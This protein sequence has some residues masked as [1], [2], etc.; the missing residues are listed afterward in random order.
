MGRLACQKDDDGEEEEEEESASRALS[1]KLKSTREIRT[2]FFHLGH[3]SLTKLWV[4][5]PY[6]ETALPLDHLVTQ[7]LRSVNSSLE[8]FTL[9]LFLWKASP[10]VPVKPSYCFLFRLLL[11][12]SSCRLM[13]HAD[14]SN[15][16]LSL[17]PSSASCSSPP[18]PSSLYIRFSA[19]CLHRSSEAMSEITS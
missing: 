15:L 13:F 7:V 19:K 2:H 11:D 5:H 1:V 6:F 9:L 16:L 8:D 17:S 12:F 3:F 10:W 14:P 4:L 18:P